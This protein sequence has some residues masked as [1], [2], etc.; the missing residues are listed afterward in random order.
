MAFTAYS[1]RPGNLSTKK[2]AALRAAWGRRSV[3]GWTGRLLAIA[4]APRRPVGD[5]EA[6]DADVL[7]QETDVPVD[8]DDVLT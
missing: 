1:E 2:R 3:T 6:D 5:R 8:D 7:E 4:A